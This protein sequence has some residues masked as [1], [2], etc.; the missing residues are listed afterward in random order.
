[1]AGVDRNNPKRAASSESKYSLMEFMRE[2]PDDATCLDFLWRTRFAPDGEHARCPKCETER[3]FKRYDNTIRRQVWN[4]TACGYCLYPTG[5]TIYHKSSTS[6]HLWFYAIYLMS[7]TR[8]GVSAKALE[9]ELGVTYKTAWRMMNL[10]RTHVMAQDE[11]PLTGDVE[12]DE[13]YVGGK[14][15]KREIATERRKG[16]GPKQAGQ[17]A[18]R[19]KKTTVYG[20]VERGGRIRAEVVPDNTGGIAPRVHRFVLP[21]ASIFTDEWVGY[22]KPGQAFNSHHRVNHAQA[23]YVDGD[24]HTNT[25]EGFWSLLKRGI[26]GT[27]HAVSAKYLQTYL[28]EYAWRYNHRDDDLGMFRA[29][30][31]RSAFPR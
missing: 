5:G 23:V 2:F 18:A 31:F 6:L 20:A 26:G 22:N 21:A 14:P 25:I 13:T 28:N 8:G 17:A 9:R 11:E 16:L 30:L 1:M 19:R 7:S 10:I 27:Y 15:R 12:M 24:V 3:T 4:C 29:M